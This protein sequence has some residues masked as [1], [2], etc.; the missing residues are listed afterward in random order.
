MEAQTIIYPGKN[1][2]AWWDMA[3][4]L[5][6][7]KDAVRIFE[8]LHPGAIGIWVFDCSSAHEALANDALNIKNMN[9]KPGGQQCQLHPTVI[10]LNNPLPKP[11][12]WDTC[13][14]IQFFRIPQTIQIL[15]FGA[16]QKAFRQS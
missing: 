4:L 8:Y 7:I 15:T 2:D 3:Q 12:K 10:P 1:A 9:I 5:A 11:G 13:G 6:Q 16:S 14:D